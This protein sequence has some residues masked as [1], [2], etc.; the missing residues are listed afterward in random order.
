LKNDQNITN[1]QNIYPD[2]MIRLADCY[3]MQKQYKSSAQY[4]DEVIKSN[5]L[6]ADYA[7]YQKPLLTDL[8]EITMIKLPA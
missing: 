2:A 8:A 6:G 5:A 7:L 1:K 4:Y 3:F